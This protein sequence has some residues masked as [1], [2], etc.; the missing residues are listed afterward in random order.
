MVIL[1]V[2]ISG[3]L[4]AAALFGRS[5]PKAAVASLANR[6]RLVSLFVIIEGLLLR[7]RH[8]SWAFGLQ[9]RLSGTLPACGRRALLP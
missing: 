6:Q 9:Q 5:G 2:A 4:L 1:S 8:R 7:N 3:G